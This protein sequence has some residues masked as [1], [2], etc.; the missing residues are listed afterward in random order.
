MLKLSHA[1]D[2]LFSVLSRLLVVD[3]NALCAELKITE[4]DYFQILLLGILNGMK[5]TI[6]FHMQML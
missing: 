5:P 6:H 4:R 3:M 1:L 2:G